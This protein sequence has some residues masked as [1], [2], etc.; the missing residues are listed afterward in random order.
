MA[1]ESIMGLMDSTTLVGFWQFSSLV[2]DEF[3]AS[4]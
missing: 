3:Q 2:S 4:M 1:R